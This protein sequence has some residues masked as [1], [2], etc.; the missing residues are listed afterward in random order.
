MRS[1]IQRTVLAVAFFMLVA[2]GFPM[3]IFNINTTRT[4]VEELLKFEARALAMHEIGRA[5]V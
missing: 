1:R 3:L 4:H 5:H 2:I